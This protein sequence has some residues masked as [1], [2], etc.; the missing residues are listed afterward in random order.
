MPSPTLHPA[1]TLL[2]LLLG[3]LSAGGEGT[4]LG[5]PDLQEDRRGVA[6]DTA[7]VVENLDAAPRP[8]A[9]IRRSPGPIEVDGTLDEPAW[10]GA[11]VI[12]EFVQQRPRDGYPPTERTEVRL[13]YDDEHLYVGAELFD[14][15]PSGIIIPTLQR[16]P[17]TRDGDAFGIVLDTFQ[18][19]S[20]A[21]A[22]FVNP[23]GAV[24]DGQ[25][26]DDGR[27]TNFAWDGA[28]ELETTVHDRGWTLEM[29]IPWSTLRFD[30][31]R[32]NQ[33]W[34]LNLMRRVR[35]KNED[36]TWAPMDRQRPLYTASR[37]GTLIGLEGIQPGRNLSLKPYMLT[38]RPNGELVLPE[39]RGTE[40]DAGLD[41]KYGL[42]PSLTLDL[43]YNTDFSQVEVDQQQVNLTRFS[44][45]FPERRDFFL[46]NQGIFSFGDQSSMGQRTGVSQQDFTL[47]HSRR[48]G[49]TPTGDPLPILGG[50]RVSGTIGS[51]DIGLINMQTRAEGDFPSENFS[52]A[53]LRFRPAQGLDVGGMAIQRRTRGEET[54]TN[55]SYG[56]DANLQVGNYLL[57]QSYFAAT[58]GTGV[59]S[60]VAGR[61]SVRYRDPFWEATALY[62]RIG[63]DFQP[64]VGFVRRRGIHHRYGTL[65]V[66]PR[67]SWPMVQQLNPFMEV[68]HFTDLEGELSTRVVTGGLEVDF[69]DGSDAS[70]LVRDQY[71]RINAPFLLR[72]AT[73]EPGEYSSREVELEA[74]SSRARS[75]SVSAGLAGGEFYGGDR[76]SLGGGIQWRPSHRFLLDLEADHNRVDLPG[77]E[78]FTADVYGARFRYFR[79]TRLLSSAFIQYNEVTDELIS[80]LRFNWIHAPL[81][82]L[83]LVLTERRAVESN[84]VMER[85]VSLKVTRLFS[86]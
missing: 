55:R 48:I 24:R 65:G 84:Q 22:F 86:F 42:T 31:G 5:G 43:T 80:N 79:S 26:S 13:L 9:T 69:L 15:D 10:E 58:Q 74:G 66:T 51:T 38:A 2:F 82:D 37:A 4:P 73:I 32:G 8:T 68:D 59:D 49:L 25:V 19:R 54:R 21:F 44:L 30:P 72:G 81:S 35:R 12:S 70:I 46:E 27:N 57:F 41:L 52:V 53:R 76:I 3:H 71:E 63:E 45:F 62:R 40:L 20:S 50:G 16:D 39:S 23:G 85:V 60:D 18:D 77:S 28:F 78:A 29:A 83:F 11:E 61:F 6:S 14:S 64:G 34:G 36:S 17:N 47:F 67:V 75:V 33:D 1:S 56:V 7:M